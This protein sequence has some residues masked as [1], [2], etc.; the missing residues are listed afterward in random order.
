MKY[1]IRILQVVTTMNRGGLETMLMNYYRHIDRSKVQFDFLVHRDFEAD[2]DKEILSLGGRIYRMDRLIP[3]SRNYKKKLIDFFKNHQEYKIVHVHQ[4]CLSSVALECAKKSNIPVRIAH[5]HT[6]SQDKNLK[7]LI[8]LFYMKQIPGVATDLFACSEV[9]GDWM[10]RGHGFKILKN[11][12]DITSYL[13]N[14]IISSKV[15]KDLNVEDNFVIG[16]VGRFNSLKNHSFL[17]DVFDKCKKLDES[18]K[19]ILVGDGDC[20]KEIEEKVHSK[21]LDKDVIFLG[22]Q[23]NVNELLQAMDVFV[24][25]SLYEGLGIAIIEA[26]TASLPCFI[27]D[28]IPDDCIV[29]KGLVKKLPL[30]A[31]PKMW[32]E[33]IIKKKSYNKH[34]TSEEI[35]VSGYDIFDS[36]RQLEQFYINSYIKALGEE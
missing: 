14:P 29:T 1:P 24:F 26:E 7:Y 22:V 6:S 19:L 10:F 32:A 16:H 21:G 20:R 31:S 17:I 3:W 18:S 13:Y 36:S 8:K 2:Y 30:N 27:S 25:P 11:A 5:S 15:K 9:A 34:D 23:N 35:K 12:V 4:D 28:T 33:E